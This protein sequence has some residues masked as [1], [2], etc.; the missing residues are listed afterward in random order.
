MEI[1]DLSEEYENTYCRC[2]EDWSPGMDEAGDYKKLWLEKKKKQGLRVK[3]AKDEQGKIVGMIQYIP[4]EHAP[5]TGSGLY[6][7][8]CIWVHGHKEGVGN[9]QKKGTG[10]LLLEAAEKDCRDLGATGM[11]A[12]GIMLP[13]FMR[14]RWFK[15]HGFKRAD[16]DGMIE[17]VWK[18]FTPG[19][20]P[21][22]L[23]KMKRKPAAVK[24]T[25]TV[26]CFRNG[27]CPAQNMSCERIKRAAAEYSD[28]I[29][30]TEIDTDIRDNLDEWGIADA[31]FVD[32]RIVPTGSP[33]TCIL[34]QGASPRSRGCPSAPF[35]CPY[36]NKC[37]RSCNTARPGEHCHI[38]R[39][40]LC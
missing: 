35:A 1:I 14:S 6:Y 20:E 15:K 28:H 23:L 29:K 30:Y 12:W 27:W 9:R 7:I 19:A 26:T 16:R 39:F 22:R 4:I 36:R 3:L 38:F 34:F 37:S 25:V 33:V 21:P 17:L 13:F 31:I 11:A 32:D 24:G 8:Y 18:P 2:L 5:V 40:S 10:T